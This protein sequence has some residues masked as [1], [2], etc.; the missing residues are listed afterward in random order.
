MKTLISIFLVLLIAPSSCDD[1]RKSIKPMAHAVHRIIEGFFA[2]TMPKVD[3]FGFKLT[4]ENEE[5][6]NS[7]ILNCKVS[8]AYQIFKETSTIS[9]KIKLNTSSILFFN[10][11]ESFK[12]NYKKIEWQSSGF[13]HK[14]LVYFPNTIK[15]D[16]GFLTNGFPID[17]VNFI[18]R[19]PD[20]TIIL[21]T[22][23]MFLPGVCRAIRFLPVNVF[24]SISLRWRNNQFYL[25]KYRNLHNCPLNAYRREDN[26]ESFYIM[27]V[28]TKFAKAKPKFI[29]AI[30][31]FNGSV[32]DLQ[33]RS[34]SIITNEVLYTFPYLIDHLTFF[35]PRGELYSP[36]EKMFQPFDV[37]LWI[38]TG[39]TLKC[40]RRNSA[41]LCL[42]LVHQP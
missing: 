15:T 19:D 3:M 16:Y 12:E 32:F 13:R 8:I 24:N 35:I 31:K 30:G 1:S 11:H 26:V 39:V 9:S 25:Q 29:N 28:Y 18:S 6:L 14:H 33:G 38:A 21:V 36:L 17:Q 4:H 41:S 5:L 34:G 37:E 27:A 2:K 10:S 7:V 23:F 42:D 22:S 40:Y 20:G